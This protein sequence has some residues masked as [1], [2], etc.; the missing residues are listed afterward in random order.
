MLWACVLLPSLALDGAL[1]RR[2]PIE[3]PFALVDGPAQQRR[4]VAVNRDA[5]R[6]GLYPGQRLAEADA[7]CRNLLKEEHD[8]R[9]R[10]ED[11][12]LIAAWAYRFSSDVVLDPPR[13]VVLEIGRSLKLFGPWPRLEIRLREELAALGFQHRIALAPNPRAARVLAGVQDGIAVT[14]ADALHAALARIPV[15]RAGLPRKAAE[16]LPGMGIRTLGQVMGL[17][18]ASLQRRFGRA[19]IEA[20]DALTGQHPANLERYQ[21]AERFEAGMELPCEITHQT[22]LLF[23]LK[24][25]LADLAAFVAARDGG[26]ETFVIRFG[27]A[28]GTFTDL[29]IGLLA[30]EREAQ[31]LFDLA[32]LRLD[33]TVLTKPVIALGVHADHLPPLIPAGRDLFD[34]RPANA[35]PWEALRERLRARLGEDAVQG[36]A[37]DPDP[38][39]ERASLCQRI[40]AAPSDPAPVLP[41]RPTWLLA[42][43]IPLRGP[44]PKV[45]A[46]PERLETGWWDGGDLRRDYYV[47][48]LDT[49]QRAWAFCAPGEHGPY[50]L[51]GWFA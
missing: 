15:A 47:L 49:G 7:I 30:P 28:Y 27:H 16:A 24:R 48:E 1:R 45:L 20:L 19:L 25:M 22:T 6:V 8:P 43:P 21:P 38:R 42:R 23:P 44:A 33:Q 10:E 41:A 3:Q 36:L 17:P 46:G 51:H 18:R 50:M 32:K 40:D 37:V 14:D 2:P 13:A 26:V 34:A 35:L 4:L 29:V 39:P 11:L 31:A 9:R 5:A 12:S